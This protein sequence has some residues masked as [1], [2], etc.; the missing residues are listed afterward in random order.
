[1][2]ETLRAVFFSMLLFSHRVVH[3]PALRAT[4]FLKKAKRC[5]LRAFFVCGGVPSSLF[6][7]SYRPKRRSR[8]K[9]EK[10]APQFSILPLRW[11]ANAKIIAVGDTTFFQVY[12]QKIFIANA[13]KAKQRNR[14]LLFPLP[15]FPFPYDIMRKIFL[16]RKFSEK[17]ER[18]AAIWT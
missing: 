15:S 3:H 5:A 6:C 12:Q 4:F 13:A 18:G 16:G 7:K 2:R 10:P 1:M 9:S 14:R 11:D 8:Q 17:Q